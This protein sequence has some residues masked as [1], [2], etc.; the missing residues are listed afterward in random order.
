MN[1]LIN[2]AKSSVISAVEQLEQ[3]AA[4]V[5]ISMV[6]DTAF[7]LS[8]RD[9]SGWRCSLHYKFHC[10]RNTPADLQERKSASIAQAAP[11]G[12]GRAV[13]VDR[14]VK[15]GRRRRRPG[16]RRESR[17]ENNTHMPCPLLS[18]R[19]PTHG[20]CHFCPRV[21]FSKGTLTLWR[22]EDFIGRAA[23]SLQ[24]AFP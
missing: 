4:S 6:F 5:F 15:K 19:S 7:P 10:Q 23:N 3:T 11:R 9:W 12:A 14:W 24:T 22:L 8:S 20:H 16:R 13:Q 1:F 21:D 17:W 2:Q 18:S